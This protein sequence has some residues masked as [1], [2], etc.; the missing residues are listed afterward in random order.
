MKIGAIG[1]ITASA[2][3]L[4][5]VTSVFAQDTSV[6]L[7]SQMSALPKGSASP[8]LMVP[9]AAGSGWGSVGAGLYAQTIKRAAPANDRFDG[10]L[11]LNFG[12]G[13]PSKYVGLDASVSIS[14][15]TSRGGS[16][17][18]H[19]GSFGLKLNTNLP[20]LTSFAVG[21][22]H[23]GR[24]GDKNSKND[25]ASVYA[26]LSRYFLVGDSGGLSATIGLGDHAFTRDD[27]GANAFGSLAW[28]FSQQ[29]SVFGEYTGRFANVGVSL[30]PFASVPFS[31]TAAAIN[32]GDPAFQGTKLGTQFAVSVGYGFSY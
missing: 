6:N 25:P 7:A 26:A 5:G 9:N 24:W 14:S 16:S 27:T 1:K 4:M 30:A 32:L 8:A 21:V 18:G 23:V 10:S 17:A 20:D 22:Q 2:T 12:L 15:L 29:L 19:N 31:V 3:L 28:Y 11:G 13:N